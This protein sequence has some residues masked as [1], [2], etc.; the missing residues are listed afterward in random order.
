MRP[1]IKL[2][3]KGVRCPLNWV[4]S[5]LALEE[6]E[7]G[8]LLEVIIDEGEPLRNVP[9]SAKAEGHKLLRVEPLGEGHFRLRME[10]G[11]PSPQE[12]GTIEERVKGKGI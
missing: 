12:A 10:R 7:P 1:T 5:K 6:M 8:Q 4:H 9:R 2:D 11:S 3:L